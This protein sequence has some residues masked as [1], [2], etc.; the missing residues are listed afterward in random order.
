MFRTRFWVAFILTLPVVFWAEHIQE[1][2]GYQAPVFA[3]SAWIPPLLGTAGLIP[4]NHH[5]STGTD[6]PPH[7]HDSR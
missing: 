1:L 3:G 6:N 7:Q 2:L 5:H 4:R